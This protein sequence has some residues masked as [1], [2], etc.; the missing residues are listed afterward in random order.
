VRFAILYTSLAF[1][2]I[3]C[4]YTFSVVKLITLHRDTFNFIKYTPQ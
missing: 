4:I 2:F 1:M 3:Y